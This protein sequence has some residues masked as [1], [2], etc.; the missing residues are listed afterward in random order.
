MTGQEDRLSTRSCR[1]TRTLNTI[2]FINDHVHAR[3]LV[4]RLVMAVHLP[5][6]LRSRSSLAK[7]LI[8]L[9][10]LYVL[11]RCLAAWMHTTSVVP[12]YRYED[13]RL[14]PIY[15]ALRDRE[16]KLPQHRESLRFPEGK[17]GAWCFCCSVIDVC[18]SGV[19]ELTSG[20]CTVLFL[21]GGILGLII[22]YGGAS[23]VV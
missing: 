4:S 8:P 19:Y 9:F 15:P 20:V 17:G 11:W 23:G 10:G 6:A 16:R 7:V 14:P 3:A 22:S 2:E 12:I 1:N 21:Q 18:A 13:Q 5:R